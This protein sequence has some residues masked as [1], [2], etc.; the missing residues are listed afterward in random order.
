MRLARAS[1]CVLACSLPCLAGPPVTDDHLKIDQFGY[2]TTAKKIAVLSDPQQGY[3]APDPYAPPATMQVRRWSDDTVAFTGPVVAF[4]G[5]ATHAQSGDRVWWFDFSTLTE[6]GSFYIFD[7][8]NNVGSYQF[9]IRDDVYRETLK[10]AV[11]SYYYQRCGTDRPAQY[12][13]AAWADGTCH[14]GTEQDTDCRWVRNTAPST[15]KDL[16]GGWHDA[17]DYNKYINFADGPVHDLLSAYENNPAAW[18]DDYGIPESGDGVPD[19]LQE[20]KYE[21]DWFLKMQLSDGSVLHKVSVTNYNAGSPPST[22]TEFRRYAEAT[23]SATISAC[24]AFAHGAIVFKAQPDPTMQ[25]YGNALQAA[26]VAAWGWLTANPGTSTYDNWGFLSAAAEDGAYEQDT[27]RVCAASYLYVLTGN[28]TYQAFFDANYAAATLIASGFAYPF[29]SEYQDGLLYYGRAPGATPS[30]VAA[31]HN[32]YTTSIQND[33]LSHYLNDDDAYIAY[34]KDQDY[35]WGSNHTKASQGSMYVNMLVYGL[36]PGNAASFGNAAAAFAHYVHGVNPTGFAYLSNMGPYGA[37]NSITTFYHSWFGDGT[38]WDT[39][40]APGFV[41]GGPNPS[42]NVNPPVI[43]PMGQPLQVVQKWY[44]DWNT[45]YPENSWEITENSCSYQGAYV[46]LLSYFVPAGGG[47]GGGGTEN[48]LAGAGLGQPNPNRIA[49]FTA[50][51]GTTALDVLAYSAGA[52]G[53]N[54]VDGNLDGGTYD[55]V[56]TGPGPGPVLGPQVRAFRR[57]ATSLNKVNYYAYGTLR[58][59]VNVTSDSVDGDP[60]GEIVT[61]AGPGQVFGPHVRGWNYDNAALTSIAKISYFAYGT[62]KFGVNAG[63][64]DVEGDTFAELLTGPGPGAVFGP[65]VRGWNYD[66]STIAAIAKINFNAFTTTQFG[67]N[68]AGGNVDGDAP[69]EIGAGIGPGAGAGFP[70]QIKGWNYDGASITALPGFDTTPFGTYYGARL[71]LA[72]V[73]STAEEDLCAGAGRDPAATSTFR[74]YTYDGTSLTAGLSF[75]A[76][77]AT[78]YGVNVGGGN[79]GY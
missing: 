20:I 3:N 49:A 63:S 2:Q 35:T 45:S 6:V 55:E 1:L 14:K 47:G 79:Y 60:Y 56:V 17:G 30:V 68:V 77:S 42:Y 73:A 67:C 36:D 39:N 48:P 76:F 21:L 31:I 64:G 25:A 4:A 43:P 75:V 53:C 61:G 46:K 16:S 5:G 32:A 27:N 23:I 37:E 9:D 19:I 11:R 50:T 40:P 71:G 15:A 10:Q 41:P 28:A 54:A 70:S 72:D 26:A 59:G 78:S 33:N 8:T 44:K 7:A 51:G 65:Q 29:E 13:G 69:S 74:V 52:W 66:G 38:P 22:D 24:G 57:D 18:A 58:Y 34:L 62:L 12:A